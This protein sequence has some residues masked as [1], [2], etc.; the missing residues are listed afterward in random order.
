MKAMFSDLIGLRSE[1]WNW[2]FPNGLFSQD[3]KYNRSIE[4]MVIIGS[5]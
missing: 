2:L 4:N 3:K 5:T 1:V